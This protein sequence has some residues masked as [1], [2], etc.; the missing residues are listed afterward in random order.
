MAAYIFF[1]LLVVGSRVERVS[2]PPSNK[3]EAAIDFE[4]TDLGGG[5]FQGSSLKGTIVLLD[6]W[7]VW[8]PPCLKAM[9]ILGKLQQDF[10]DEGFQVLGIAVYSGTPEDVSE[11]IQEHPVDYPIV[12]GDDDL[13]ERF[14]IIGYPTYFL[15]DPEGHIYKKYVGER[16]DLY[17][18]VAEDIEALKKNHP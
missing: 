13:I 5:R 7:A 6:F 4:A 12:V 14:A 10:E 2:P 9:P 18:R 16:K 11:F 3:V 8:C 1:L 15:I 17:E